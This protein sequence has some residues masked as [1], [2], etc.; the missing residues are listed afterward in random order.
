MPEIIVKLGDRIVQKFLLIQNQ[1]LS[2]GRSPENDITIENP[3]VSRR[4]ATIEPV[5]GRYILEDQQSANGTYVNGVRITK[6]EILDRDVMTIGKHKLHFYDQTLAQNPVHNIPMQERTMV[7]S[8]EPQAPVA[9][10]RIT[11]GKQK[12]V[13]YPLDKPE[14]RLGKSSDNDI[15][16]QDWFV[17]KYHAIISKRGML[18]VIQDLDSSRLAKTKVNGQV[19]EEKVLRPGDEIELGKKIIMRFEMPSA[20]GAQEGGGRKPVELAAAGSPPEAAEAQVSHEEDE[21]A[22]VESD[23]VAAE[24]SAP[25]E[26]DQDEE[27]LAEEDESTSM[28]QE[29]E[30][31]P[32]TSADPILATN[33][34]LSDF[35]VSEVFEFGQGE[36]MAASPAPAEA[37]PNLASSE[38]AEEPELTLEEPELNTEDASLRKRR[39]RKRRSDA[40]PEPLSNTVTAAPS[41]SEYSKNGN[42]S[43][44]ETE[45]SVGS[46]AP[47]Q[48][49]EA[50]PA[51]AVATNGTS[52]PQPAPSPQPVATQNDEV[53][54]WEKALSNPSPVIRK[55]AQRKLK[56]LTGRDYAI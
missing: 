43:T 24:S 36:T 55:Q 8:G 34:A 26:F 29:L 4:H 38:A 53:S 3:A 22:E 6:T 1:R 35:E 20:A 23:V 16:L 14:I 51:P 12:D 50:P 33:A 28:V 32:I 27:G 49:K 9:Y 17:S 13:N 31:E 39:R 21:V 40:E 44:H 30:E 18:Y 42:S 19:I 10:L 41:E 2:I 11:Q 52:A 37:E 56:Q 54:L 48:Q 5:E 47:A 7:V 25:N 15:R 46:R 45:A